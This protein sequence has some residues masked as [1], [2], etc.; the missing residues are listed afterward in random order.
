MSIS[1]VMRLT[2]NYQSSKGNILRDLPVNLHPFGIILILQWIERQCTYEHQAQVHGR[3]MRA[4]Q[5]AP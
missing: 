2:R 3:S 1:I 4:I 5:L